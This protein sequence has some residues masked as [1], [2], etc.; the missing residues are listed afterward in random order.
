M[1]TYAYPDAYLARFCTPEREARAITDVQTM[2]G[3]KTLSAEWTER[4]VV[5]QTY[6]LACQEQMA[7]PDD[8]FAAKLKVY[9]QQLTAQLP[10]ALLAADA[11]AGEVSSLGLFSIPLQRG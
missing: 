9:R 6:I 8:L 10:Q 3:S 11:T 7:A 2:A 4:L 1:T 5:T